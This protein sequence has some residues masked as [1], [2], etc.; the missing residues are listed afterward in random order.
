MSTK[1]LMM[2]HVHSQA[3][4]K[5]TLSVTVQ[6]KCTLLSWLVA[7][8]FLDAERQG[9]TGVGFDTHTKKNV[10]TTKPVSL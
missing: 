6:L 9:P 1:T 2:K 5:K 3:V 7:T 10:A 4:G 8:V